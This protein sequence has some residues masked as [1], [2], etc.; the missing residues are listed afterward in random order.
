MNATERKIMRDLLH[1]VL[2]QRDEDHT[3]LTYKD[4]DEHRIVERAKGLLGMVGSDPCDGCGI[5]VRADEYLGY[6]KPDGETE[7]KCEHCFDEKYHGLSEEQR[8]WFPDDEGG[9]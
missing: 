9:E 3:I 1:L 6:D 8:Q 7:Y 4:E 2:D 5:L